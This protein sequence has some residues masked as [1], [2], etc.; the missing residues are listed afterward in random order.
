G[1]DSGLHAEEETVAAAYCQF[2]LKFGTICEGD[3]RAHIAAIARERRET[4]QIVAHAPFHEQIGPQ[5]DIVLNKERESLLAELHTRVG[6]DLQICKR[7]RQVRK[8]QFGIARY[9][10]RQNVGKPCQKQALF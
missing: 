1:E 2:L 9:S 3:S 6:Q 5:L 8:R 4:V 10:R 7:Q